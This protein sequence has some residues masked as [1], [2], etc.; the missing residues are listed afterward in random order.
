MML[1]TTYYAKLW[2][3]S[4]IAKIEKQVYTCVSEHYGPCVL[5]Q[6]GNPYECKALREYSGTCFCEVY[7]ADAAKG[8]MLL[9]RIVPGTELKDTPALDERLA[10]F[11]DVWQ[12]LHAVPAGK[13]TY[14]TYMDWVSRITAYMCGRDDHQALCEKMTKAEQICREL[15]AT[16]PGE[17]LLH[18]DLHH[19]NILLGKQGRW[20]IID[21]KGVVGDPVFDIPRFI[22]NEFDNEF[23]DTPDAAKLVYAIQR[24]SESIRVPAG[25]LGRLLFVETCMG[26]CWTVEEGEAPDIG[27]VNFAEKLMD[28]LR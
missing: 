19:H 6:S 25:D 27:E 20:R 28:E 14:Q 2:A 22:L 1:D 24:L 16:Y 10:I 5:K 12:N 4:G 11:C 3:L 21:P 8:V 15:C 7:E 18:G 9:E 13:A 17:M 23:G 26:Q